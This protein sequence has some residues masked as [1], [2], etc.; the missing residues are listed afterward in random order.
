MFYLFSVCICVCQ[1]TL[2]HT[3][4]YKTILC[5]CIHILCMCFLCMYVYNN[6]LLGIYAHTCIFMFACL[7]VHTCTHM[8]GSLCVYGWSDPHDQPLLLFP[9]YRWEPHLLWEHQGSLAWPYF[10]TLHGLL[11]WVTMEVGRFSLQL[12]LLGIQLTVA[13][14]LTNA[15]KY[16]QDGPN[17]EIE[18]R[19]MFPPSPATQPPAL[20]PQVRTLRMAFTPRK[21]FRAVLWLIV[22]VSVCYSSCFCDIVGTPSKI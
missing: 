16:S 6:P 13:I 14:S 2:W 22:P 19:A 1:T 20:L 21:T 8:C 10:I 18:R 15:W 3:C 11:W 17:E 7:H 9:F 12:C 4:V 5:V